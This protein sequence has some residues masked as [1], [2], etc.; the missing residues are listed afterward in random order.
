MTGTLSLRNANIVEDSRGRLIVM[1]RNCE[2]VIVDDTGRER[3]HHRVP[4]GTV[5]IDE[6]RLQGEARRQARRLGSRTPTP[7]ITE[8]D[9]IAHFMSISSKACR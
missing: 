9:G 7:I 1:S 6:G 4:Y 3:A 2:V 5:V 8:R